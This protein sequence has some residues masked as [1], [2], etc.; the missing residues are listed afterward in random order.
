MGPSPGRARSP[1]IQK[2]QLGRI[3]FGNLDDS[4]SCCGAVQHEQQEARND[5]LRAGGHEGLEPLT[6]GGL[7]ARKHLTIRAA[8]S[9]ESGRGTHEPPFARVDV[10]FRGGHSLAVTGVTLVCDKCGRQMWRP[11]RSNRGRAHNPFDTGCRT[12]LLSPAFFGLVE[13][14][15]LSIGPFNRANGHTSRTF[16]VHDC[17]RL[18]VHEAP[19]CPQS[20]GNAHHVRAP[21]DC[22]AEL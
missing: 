15:R 6:V 12:V 9:V 22:Y 14:L 13:G 10:F 4:Q 18:R 7:V 1:P 2:H 3:R 19:N 5:E 11:A 17:A 16:C 21:E 20:Q 8:H